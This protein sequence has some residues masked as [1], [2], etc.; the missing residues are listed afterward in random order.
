MNFTAQYASGTG[1]A[2]QL[3]TS[4]SPNPDTAGT[5]FGVGSG[6]LQQQSGPGTL[7]IPAD[8]YFSGSDV[9][10]VFS[11]CT[12]LYIYAFGYDSDYGTGSYHLYG[13]AV[14]VVQFAGS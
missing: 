9:L 13:A 3:L 7:G 4:F 12:T 14:D 10:T 6:E 5:A 11:C 8:A 1:V 2:P